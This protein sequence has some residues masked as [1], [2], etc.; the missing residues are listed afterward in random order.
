MEK[1]AKCEHQ[2]NAK[3]GTNPRRNR[4]FPKEACGN[5]KYTMMFHLKNPSM[6][7]VMTSSPIA[8]EISTTDKG[9]FVD[10]V[11]HLLHKV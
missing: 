10:D 3:R 1:S 11:L 5:T 4:N 9:L 2:P 7:F 8:F 6:G